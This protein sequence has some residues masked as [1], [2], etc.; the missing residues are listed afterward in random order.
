MPLL[1]RW[2]L[3]ISTLARL[4]ATHGFVDVIKKCADKECIRD[5]QIICAKTIEK[6]LDGRTTSF[7]LSK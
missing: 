3:P 5:W 6:R 7:L 4:A 1:L 2:W